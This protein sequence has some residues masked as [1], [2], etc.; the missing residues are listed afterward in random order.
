M[1][2]I[3]TKHNKLP[4]PRHRRRGS[5]RNTIHPLRQSMIFRFDMPCDYSKYP[6][7]WFTEIR[8]A[9]L[10]RAGDCCEQCGV[11]NYEYVF[12]GIW[13][14]QEV[15]QRGNGDLFSVDGKLIMHNSEYEVIDGKTPDSKAVKIVLTISHTD[16]DTSNNDYNNLK[17][18]CQLH[19]LR[20]D[21]WH[22]KKTRNQSKGLQ[23]LF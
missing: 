13:N 21:I 17:A 16:H 8:P 11:K 5:V 6:D 14:N 9:I 1:C 12:R 15:F 4:P 2:L 20:H 23:S 7:N 19:H 18:L 10:G 3:P 22:H